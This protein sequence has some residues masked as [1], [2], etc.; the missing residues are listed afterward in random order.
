MS[1]EVE[2]LRNALEDITY[3]EWKRDAARTVIEHV[4][5]AIKAIKE[6]DRVKK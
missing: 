3:L 5:I 6:A 1:K 2:I 4:K